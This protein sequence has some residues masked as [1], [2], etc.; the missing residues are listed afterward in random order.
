[1]GSVAPQVVPALFIAQLVSNIGLWMETVGAQWFLVDRH[2]GPVVIALVQTA[3]LAPTLLL[4]LIAGVFADTFDRRRLLIWLSLYSAI[5]GFV[6]AI[7]AWTDVLTAV[8]LLVTT[9]LLG[10]GVALTS[11]PWQAIQ[12]ELVDRDEIPA[13]SSLGSF[14]VNAARAIGPAI[15]GVLVAAAGPAAVFALNGVSYLAVVAALIAWRRQPQQRVVEREHLGTSMRVGVRYLLAAPTVRRILLRSFL[16]AFPGSALW[17]LLPVATSKHLH[18]GSSGYGL[19][20]G[21]LGVGAMMGVVVVGWARR[22]LPSSVILA[23]SALLF[24]IATAALAVAPLWVVLVVLFIAGIAWI[25]T[26]TT[27]N[28]GLQLTLPAW[29]RARGMAMYL[30]VFMGSQS[31]GSLIWGAVASAIG[32]RDALFIAAL[33]LI[34]AAVSV[35]FW[36]LKP[37]TGTMNRDLSMAWPTP[38]LIFEPAPDDGPVLVS[39]T[40]HLKP[41]SLA[42][43][44]KAMARVGR[45]RRRTGGRSWRLYCSADDDN[46]A[47]EQFV[48]ESWSEYQRQHSQRWT[49]Y[50]HEG[51]AAAL[52]FT[53][54]GVTHEERL[55]GLSA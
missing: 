32:F 33:L 7:L 4:S 40:Y 45:S 37:T 15:G 52:Q 14:T 36:P 30:M 19:V 50:D 44:T 12:P 34:L 54:D 16:F 43:F 17:A 46:L 51:V 2:A 5:V 3:S 41:G 47:V 24:A 53:T 28:A 20:L 25:E 35:W 9:F 13:A 6:M 55:F 26:L 8:G 22:K 31:I 39:I 48:V 10:V 29:V 11:P 1:M 49:E 42:D 18:L 23:V 21:V 38:T 27:L